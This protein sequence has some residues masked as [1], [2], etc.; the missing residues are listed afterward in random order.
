MSE[1]DFA[2]NFEETVVRGETLLYDLQNVAKKTL[3]KRISALGFR[4]VLNGDGSDE[5][6]GGYNF[7]KADRLLQSDCSRSTESSMTEQERKALFD[8]E[9]ASSWFGH[10]LAEH[11]EQNQTEAK[12]SLGIGPGI[13]AYASQSFQPW[14]KPELFSHLPHDSLEALLSELDPDVRQALTTIHPLHRSMSLWNAA[15]LPNVVIAAISDGAEMAHSV[16]SRPPFLDHVVAEYANRLPVD[17]KVRFAGGRAVEKWI[18]REAV[19]PFVTQEVYAGAKQ[20][21]AAPWRWQRDGPLRRKMDE[22][23]CR[24]NIDRLGFADWHVCNT[25]VERAFGQ[26]D[27]QSFRQVIWLAQIVCLGKHFNVPP[28]HHAEE[29]QRIA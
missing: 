26:Q 17:V 12:R 24:S 2:E 9:V 5:L 10:S 3:S 6:F 29:Q 27:Q 21:F 13:I 22:L 14:E 15:L 18:F 4:V 1:S 16:E 7:F 25:L 8:K 20:A 23:I 28:A 11:S 19:R